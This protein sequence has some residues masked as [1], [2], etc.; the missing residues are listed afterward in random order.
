M[1]KK[2]FFDMIL[3]IVATSIPT[4]VLQL[5]ILPSLSNYMDGNAYGLMVTILAVLN[6]VPSTIGNVLNNVR[7]LH[8]ESYNKDNEQGDFQILLTIFQA[9]NLLI[10]V[11]VS[12]YYLG[13]KDITAVFPS[14]SLPARCSRFS[15]I[16]RALATVSCVFFPFILTTA[17]IPQLSCSNSGR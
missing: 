2:I 1:K 13:T 11:T 4:V 6:V 15:T 14:A 7:L 8:E 12:I 16:L 3:N 17:P 10:M 5:L 9:I